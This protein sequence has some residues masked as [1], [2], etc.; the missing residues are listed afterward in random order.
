M[1]RLVS[2][3]SKRVA[4]R[5]CLVRLLI[6]GVPIKAIFFKSLDVSTIKFL[7]RL[8]YLDSKTTSRIRGGSYRQENILLQIKDAMSLRSGRQLC[9]KFKI[10]TLAG[11]D[12][13]GT[14]C[15]CRPPRYEHVFFRNSAVVI[16]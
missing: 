11:T 9:E 13:P 3:S 7:M 4:L 10:I 5:E 8:S 16:G 6:T 1:L 15:F 14:I 12:L 2:L